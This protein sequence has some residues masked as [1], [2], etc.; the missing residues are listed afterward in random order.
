MV[1]LENGFQM[2]LFS[3]RNIISLRLDRCCFLSFRYF[4]VWKFKWRFK[5]TLASL[6]LFSN[7]KILEYPGIINNINF[8]NLQKKI[9]KKN[10]ILIYK[11]YFYLYLEYFFLSLFIF[12]LFYN[13]IFFMEQIL[14]VRGEAL[15]K[16]HLYILVWYVWM[17]YLS[18][19]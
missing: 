15:K 8:I 1:G 17:V 14:A 18:V 9:M 3:M 11:K 10:H 16:I 19:D 2:L 4:F 6:D 7:R 12:L 13:Y 5:L